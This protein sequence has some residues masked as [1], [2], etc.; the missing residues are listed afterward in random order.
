[1]KIGE[2]VTVI[3]DRPIGSHHPLY[4][5]LVYLLNYGYIKGVIAGVV[6]EQDAYIMGID[7]PINKF[8]GK[9]IAIIHR[10]NDI[11]NKL[12]VCPLDQV[13]TKAQIRKATYFQEQYFKIEIE[14]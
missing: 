9:V 4:E 11:E 10:L 12:V 5:H 8:R 13:Y 7:Y 2:I 1:M 6:E 14:M 3:V